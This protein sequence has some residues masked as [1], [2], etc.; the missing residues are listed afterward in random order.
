[1]TRDN[2]YSVCDKLDV[3]RVQIKFIKSI[4]GVHRKACNSA[5]RGEVG[6][7]PLLVQSVKPTI[8][9]L[10][11]LKTL[12]MNSLAYKS[13]QQCQELESRNKPSW[14][15][16]VKG[17][18]TATNNQ[19]EWTKIMRDHHY[20]PWKVWSSIS[21][22]IDNLY[23]ERWS[24]EISPQPTLGRA[25]T[26]KLRTYAKFKQHFSLENYLLVQKSKPVR[27][28]FT[29]LRISAHKLMI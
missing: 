13:Y 26:S 8:K 28:E 3:E 19:E 11:R 27:A 25:S 20:C 22:E 21:S 23:I 17:I 12:P 5:V 1:M 15:G 18:F 7:L 9:Y 2:I 4:L 14:L 29:K 6:V 16:S 10:C 24:N